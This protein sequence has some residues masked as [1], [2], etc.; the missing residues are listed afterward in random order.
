M[1]ALKAERNTPEGREEFMA[2]VAEGQTQSIVVQRRGSGVG[3][4]GDEL[5]LQ[6]FNNCKYRP[7]IPH[8]RLEIQE[9]I[10]P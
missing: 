4:V 10:A 7:G 6:D 8:G 9:E 5:R 2:C 3:L 1:A